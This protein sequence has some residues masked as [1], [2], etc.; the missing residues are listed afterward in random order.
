MALL[1]CQPNALMVSER[2]YS[3]RILSRCPEMI[4]V[5]WFIFHQIIDQALSVVET[6]IE[7]LVAIHS[8]TF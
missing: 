3:D 8:V 6:E 5:R 7:C 1:F 2:Q 4:A